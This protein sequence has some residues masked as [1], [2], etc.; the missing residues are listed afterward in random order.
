ML[1]YGNSQAPT[2]N[3]PTFKAERFALV[4]GDPVLLQLARWVCTIE[5]GYSCPIL[6]NESFNVQARP[7]SVHSRRDATAAFKTYNIDHKG[8]TLIT[9]LAVGDTALS[10]WLCLIESAYE[11][12]KFISACVLV[13][14]TTEPDWVPIMER[15]AAIITG[16]GGRTSH[17]AIVANSAFLPSWTPGRVWAADYVMCEIPPS[18]VL[19]EQLAAQFDGSSIWSNDLTQLTLGNE[20]DSDELAELF[21]EQGEA[22]KTLVAQVIRVARRGG[23]KVGICGQAP[24]YRPE[25]ARFLVEV[26]IDSVSVIPDSFVKVKRQVVASE[27]KQNGE[28]A[29]EFDFMVCGDSK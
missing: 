9:G 21:D 5:T 2:R 24:S 15:A 18:A 20:S 14:A 1:I 22:A 29:D 19:A 16:H 25:F 10:V 11:M 8:R 13:T 28:K 26:G 17:A 3:A 12:D 23:C 4:F 6:T 7:E 27:Q